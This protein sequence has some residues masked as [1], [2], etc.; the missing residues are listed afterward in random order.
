MLSFVLTCYQ[1]RGLLG[2]ANPPV[3]CLPEGKQ[4][5]LGNVTAQQVARDGHRAWQYEP[6]SESGPI[7][8]ATCSAH[9]RRKFFE[10][11]DTGEGFNRH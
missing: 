1:D 8:K 4:R 2:P 3:G 10:M 11:A 9:G 7:R 5:A 6:G